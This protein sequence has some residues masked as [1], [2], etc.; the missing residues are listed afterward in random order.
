MK[1]VVN[2]QIVQV[3]RIVFK[4]YNNNN[5]KY[6]IMNTINTSKITYHF[7]ISGALI[8]NPITK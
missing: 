2:Y 4:P 5:T 7:E 1:D 6:L 8:Y 3:K